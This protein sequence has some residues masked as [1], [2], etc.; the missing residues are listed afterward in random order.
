MSGFNQDFQKRL[1][2]FA[3]YSQANSK[4]FEEKGLKGQN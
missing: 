3:V 4:E 2:S 1:A